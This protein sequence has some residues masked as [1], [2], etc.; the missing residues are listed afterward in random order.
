MA[1]ATYLKKATP[2]I[3]EKDIDTRNIVKGILADIRS[4]G[5]SAVCELAVYFD[6]WKRGFI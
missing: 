5:E 1:M 2:P 4:R 6:N 3:K